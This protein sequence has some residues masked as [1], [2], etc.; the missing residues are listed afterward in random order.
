MVR[1]INFSI[2]TSENVFFNS[3]IST[4]RKK[5]KKKKRVN[6]ISVMALKFLYTCSTDHFRRF[7][8]KH[9]FI[10]SLVAHFGRGAVF[11]LKN[12]DI[13]NFQTSLF[14]T[15]LNSFEFALFVY[16][17]LINALKTAIC[18]LLGN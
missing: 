12:E 8:P 18:S 16:F 15:A 7:Y 4:R 11:L 10:S 2:C 9:Y 5:K 1:S 13:L 6:Y 3:F 17:L 14:R